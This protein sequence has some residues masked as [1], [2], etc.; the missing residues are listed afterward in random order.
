MRK[1]HIGGHRMMKMLWYKHGMVFQK[2]NVAEMVWW[3]MLIRR[4]CSKNSTLYW[5]K[6][7]IAIWT[8]LVANGLKLASGAQNQWYLQPAWG[9]T[10]KRNQRL[11]FVQSCKRTISGRDGTRVWVWESVGVV[12]FDPKWIKTPTSVEVQSKRSRNSSSVD[13][14]DAQTHI[15]LNVDTDEIP[16]DIEEITPPRRPPRCDKA[17]R[18]ARHAEE[19]EPKEKDAAEMRAKFDEHNLLQKEKKMSWNV[20]I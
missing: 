15:N 3:K 7:C 11:W 20:A 16:D 12:W 10:T 8:C 2:T 5:W 14:S 4:C 9:T 19:V 18:T 17:R 6:N 1:L 13:V